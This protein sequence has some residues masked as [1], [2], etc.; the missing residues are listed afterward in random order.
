MQTCPLVNERRRIVFRVE[1]V[2]PS[3][4]ALQPRCAPRLTISRCRARRAI[5]EE[6]AWLT[7]CRIMDHT[8]FFQEFERIGPRLLTIP[9]AEHH[10][11][12]RE[13]RV[14]WRPTL[15][16]MLVNCGRQIDRFEF[17]IH[18]KGDGLREALLPKAPVTHQR[19]LRLESLSFPGTLKR[20]TGE[21]GIEGAVRTLYHHYSVAPAVEAIWA[22][23]WSESAPEA[24]V[25][26]VH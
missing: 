18:R 7:I 19:R 16:R 14:G 25:G 13:P 8:S 1:A 3:G 15:A 10:S 17:V 12:R 5:P 20:E 4:I 23:A 6:D 11:V 9:N 26:I 22:A 21:A 2:D 24:G